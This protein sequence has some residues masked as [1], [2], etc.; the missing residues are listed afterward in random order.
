M[1]QEKDGRGIQEIQTE[2]FGM[3]NASK[4]S[5]EI[6]GV[7]IARMRDGHVTYADIFGALEATRAF[8]EVEYALNCREKLVQHRAN[9]A[10]RCD[11]E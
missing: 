1:V 6:M 10:T 2:G 7:V 11:E 9:Y 8:F 3:S 4:L 5:D